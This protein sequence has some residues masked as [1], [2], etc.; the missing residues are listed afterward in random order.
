MRFQSVSIFFRKYFSPSESDSASVETSDPLT[1]TATEQQ[2]LDQFLCVRRE[3][4]Q[5]VASLAERLIAFTSTTYILKHVHENVDYDS[6]KEITASDSFLFILEHI[7]SSIVKLICDE[8]IRLKEQALAEAHSNRFEPASYIQVKIHKKFMPSEQ[9]A[10]LSYLCDWTVPYLRNHLEDDGKFCIVVCA[11]N[12]MSNRDTLGHNSKISSDELT[13]A[14]IDN[15]FSFFDSAYA[16]V[17]LPQCPANN[18][19]QKILTALT[20]ADELQIDLY[21]LANYVCAAWY[22]MKD[23]LASKALPDPEKAMRYALGE[24]LYVLG[25]PSQLSLFEA[26]SFATADLKKFKRLLNSILKIQAPL[27]LGLN[28]Y[29]KLDYASLL[30]EYRSNFIQEHS[31]SY[32]SSLKPYEH[33]IIKSYL[34]SIKDRSQSYE[35]SFRLLCT[36][37][38]SSKTEKLF[39][40]TAKRTAKK[41]VYELTE[42]LFSEKPEGVSTEDESTILEI[43]SNAKG[44]LEPDEAEQLYQFKSTYSHLFG[45]KDALTKEWNKLIYSN[46]KYED[47]NFMLSLTKCIINACDSS[48]ARAEDENVSNTAYI[49][50]RLA[51]STDKLLRKNYAVAT[52]FSLRFGSCLRALQE[53]MPYTFFITDEDN[54]LPDYAGD[55]EKYEEAKR[56]GSL[57]KRVSP[58]INFAE[59]FKV[60]Q[61]SNKDLKPSKDTIKNALC[62]KFELLHYSNGRKN[63]SKFKLSWSFDAGKIPLSMHLN[64]QEIREHK[65]SFV[66]GQFIPK[67]YTITGQEA[68]LS[69]CKKDT[70]DC[71]TSDE[72]N[73]HVVSFKSSETTANLLGHRIESLIEESLANDTGS[74]ELKA[75]ITRIADIYQE[76]KRL[77]FEV[78][79]RLSLSK[80][81]YKLTQQ[82]AITYAQLQAAIIES[83]CDHDSKEALK[84]KRTLLLGELLKI[85][86]AYPYSNEK[87]N[88]SV[89]TVISTPFAVENIRSYTAKLER[90]TK[91]ITSAIDGTLFIAQRAMFIESLEKDI[92]FPDAPEICIPLNIS[93]NDRPMYFKEEIGGYTL[94]ECMPN[95]LCDG[96]NL[97][98]PA[99]EYTDAVINYVQRYIQTRPFRPEQFTLMLKECRSPEIT[100]SIYNAINTNEALSDIFFNL[101]IVNSDMTT[102]A[103][104]FKHFEQLRMSEENLADEGERHVRVYT[105]VSSTSNSAASYSSYLNYSQFGQSQEP[106]YRIA[107]MS[108]MFHIFDEGAKIDYEEFAVPVAS[109]EVNILPSIVNRNVSKNTNRIGKFLVNQVLPL[110]RIQLFNSLGLCTHKLSNVDLKT[111][112][113]TLAQ[114]LAD[115]GLKKSGSILS[116]DS[117]LPYLSLNRNSIS[118][119]EHIYALIMNTHDHSDVVAFIDELQCKRLVLNKDRRIVYYNKLKNTHLNLLASS[120]AERHNT[121]RHLRSLYSSHCKSVDDLK[122]FEDEFIK[123]A[124]IDAVDISGSMLLRAE[125]REKNTKELMGNVL[126]KYI[127]EQ[128]LSTLCK[129][130]DLNSC[131]AV[132]KPVFVSLDDYHMKLVGKQGKHADILSLHVFKKSE[133]SEDEN[134]YLLIVGVIESKF[135]DESNNQA[136]DKSCAQTNESLKAII[137]PFTGDYIDRRQYLSIF[138][139]M[140]A[141]NCRADSDRGNAEF[142]DIQNLIREEHVDIMF[143][144]FSMVFSSQI[145]QDNH[146]N[147]T[148]SASLLSVDS[149]KI[150]SKPIE[151]IQLDIQQQAVSS[152]IQSYTRDRCN[153]NGNDLSN[154]NC[155]TEMLDAWLDPQNKSMAALRKYLSKTKHSPII[156]LPL[157]TR[158]GRKRS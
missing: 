97:V 123:A 126:S 142:A 125:N 27:A 56:C 131:A 45:S 7:D 129:S 104:I 127:T 6:N 57:S 115:Q 39:D 137:K 121:E 153:S 111:H 77:Y 83:L 54:C 46:D 93:T 151:F 107:D 9:Y 34:R 147:K 157:K 61:N 154:T 36:I 135:F 58:I 87:D 101:L 26:K 81:S 43:V 124:E 109:D 14:L 62:I 102:S 8:L 78:L 86:L 59:F 21:T 99:K 96:S 84:D 20:K 113:H 67:I 116:V 79:D 156:P 140:L 10:N 112:S 90:L 91:I 71:Y 105:L 141:D 146:N 17:D 63:A 103:A 38:W 35:E 73:E 119:N 70:F 47:S 158:R 60:A 68:P 2:D 3:Q 5:K 11:A 64:L 100:E 88:L 138:A 132:P 130:L 69:L 145:L 53:K 149:I 4:A 22:K 148:L 42:E 94:Y 75:K 98:V 31:E 117:F 144:G 40:V 41:T 150:K 122:Q 24:C 128:I 114:L 74:D 12:R 16:D 33:A 1:I 134:K 30:N 133:V 152:L 37:E 13:I 19:L 108:I 92:H 139:D 118:D 155:N 143:M 82:L 28:K 136:S 48:D 52:Q 55:K 32:D 76:F 23:L 51:E 89:D 72:Y 44:S 95:S 65:D 120:T 15:V 18:S 66:L 106:Q 29:E 50:L 110:S 80:L 25:V 49:E 85:G